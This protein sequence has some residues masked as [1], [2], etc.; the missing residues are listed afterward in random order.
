MI[1]ITVGTIKSQLI[2]DNSFRKNIHRILAL[3]DGT[4]LGAVYS[5]K[6]WVLVAVMIVSGFLLRT[7][8]HPGV[9]V[10][11]LYGAVGW[12]LLLSSRLGWMEL[13]RRI[14]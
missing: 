3:R 2:L 14:T 12:G 7:L 5:W 1:A 9:F 8:T 13:F 11:T 4:C 10:G 6:L